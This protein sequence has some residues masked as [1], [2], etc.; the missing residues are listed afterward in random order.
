MKGAFALPKRLF[1]L[2]LC[3][4]IALPACAQ[5]DADAYFDA[6]FAREDP[7]AAC[8]LVS[9]QGEEIYRYFTG[10]ADEAGTLPVT[11]DTPFKCA[12]VTK[13]VT[14][15]GL[16]QL[17]EQGAFRLDEPLETYYDRPIVNPLRG[18]APITLRQVMTHTSSIRESAPYSPVW[19][20]EKQ[21][22]SY[23]LNRKPGAYYQYANLNG[24]LVGSA[25]E[26]FSG[27]SLEDYMQQHLF[28]P[29]AMD[30]S[31]CPVYLK[32]PQSISA[33]F[34][35]NKSVYMTAAQYL[36]EAALY[37]NTCSP[38]THYRTAVGSLWASPRALLTLGQMLANGGTWQG[39]TILRE[40]TVRLMLK[41]Q[42][43]ENAS[44]TAKS[45]YALMLHRLDDSR[46]GDIWYGHQGAWEGLLC[47]VYFEDVTDTVMVLIVNGSA[48]TRTQGETADIAIAALS[49]ITDTWLE[50][51]IVEE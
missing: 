22:E 19:G 18:Y 2:L 35:A 32:Q 39:K 31:Y 42:R 49:Y 3:C 6:L 29:L 51:I 12:S 40:E 48:H 13:M 44:V 46:L 41:D 27:Q 45:P 33:T 4:L 37:D 24:G 16:M 26:L 20:N 34:R 43:T 8:M 30:A 25:I 17:W 1:A 23:F 21:A 11:E 47:D 38:Y 36:E 7:V 14:A 28:A 10:F 15:V 50:G 5:E 9:R